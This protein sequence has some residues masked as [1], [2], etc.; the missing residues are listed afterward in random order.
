V[1]LSTIMVETNEYMFNEVFS[2]YQLRQVSVWNWSTI[3]VPVIRDLMMGAEMVPKTFV[4][5]RHLM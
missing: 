2:G 1:S 3:S 5:Y 4:S